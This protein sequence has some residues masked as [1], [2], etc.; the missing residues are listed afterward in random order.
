[1]AE[2]WESKSK[3]FKSFTS[4]IDLKDVESTIKTAADMGIELDFADF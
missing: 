3:T 4:G 2:E 1:M